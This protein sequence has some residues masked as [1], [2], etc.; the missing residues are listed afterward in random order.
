MQ[1]PPVRVRKM[2]P[3]DKS[4]WRLHEEDVYTQVR[5]GHRRTEHTGPAREGEA[6]LGAGPVTMPL[7]GDTET[8]TVEYWCQRITRDLG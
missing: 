4:H 8:D 7:T 3:A 6:D 2:G 1:N 5:K